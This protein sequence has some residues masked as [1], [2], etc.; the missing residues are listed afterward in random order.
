M[1]VR[2]TAAHDVG[3]RGDDRSLGGKLVRRGWSSSG[4]EELSQFVLDGVVDT[5]GEHV[6][7]VVLLG[8]FIASTLV[9]KRLA[10]R[11]SA[12]WWLTPTHTSSRPITCA[13]WAMLRSPKTLSMMTSA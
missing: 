5:G 2:R 12:R 9:G 1:T 13:T 10:S 4:G 6:V 8:H 7:E 11:F 3:H